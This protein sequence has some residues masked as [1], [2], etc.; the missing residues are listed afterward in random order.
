MK[1]HMRIVSLIAVSLVAPVAFGEIVYTEDCGGEGSV[2][3]TTVSAFANGSN[4]HDEAGGWGWMSYYTTEDLYNGHCY[5]EVYAYAD[6]TL[7][8]ADGKQCQAEG[9]GSASAD[10]PAG[11][12]S[13][14][15]YVFLSGSGYSGGQS[16]WN[17]QSPP[18]DHRQADGFMWAWT[19]TSSSQSAGAGAGVYPGSGETAYGHGCVHAWCSLSGS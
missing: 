3:A 4:P 13:R 8:F 6:A 7:A 14:S 15:A 11:S 18:D 12:I 1:S 19:S 17:A 9:A 2:G 5:Y 10:G 16:G